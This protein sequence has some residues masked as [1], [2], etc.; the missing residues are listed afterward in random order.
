MPIEM[1]LKLVVCQIQAV[2]V[3]STFVEELCG[4]LK[5][6]RQS[7]VSRGCVYPSLGHASCLKRVGILAATITNVALSVPTFP[8]KPLVTT[9]PT[10]W[11]LP[12]AMVQPIRPALPTII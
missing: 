3:Q 11:L 2:C 7:F 12:I 4:L 9:T 5:S 10:P 6:T 8:I 1:I